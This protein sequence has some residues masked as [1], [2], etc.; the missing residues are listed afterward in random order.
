[1]RPLAPESTAVAPPVLLVHGIWKS[2]TQLAALARRLRT[3]GLRAECVDLHPADGSA[4]ILELAGQVARA[5]DALLASTGAPGLDLVGFSMGA[6]VVRAYIQR[7]DG[8]ARVR[9]YVS[10]A[11]PH[12]GT[13]TARLLAQPGARDMRP[14]SALL[15][16]LAADP[17]PWGPVEV[18]AFLTPYDLMVVPA[19]T[20]LLA[21]ARSTRVFPVLL[22]RWMVSDERVLGAVVEVLT[23]APAAVP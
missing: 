20:S 4:P 9:R 1:M 10:I 5:A 7:L 22:H 18:H 19:R 2:G 15:A 16:S 6:L 14:G 21:G 3:A 12:A 17:D 23:A 11:G 13:L 8:R